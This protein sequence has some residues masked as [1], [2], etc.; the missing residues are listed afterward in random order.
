V[1]KKFSVKHQCRDSRHNDSEKKFC[2]CYQHLL[3]SLCEIRCWGQQ[4][5]QLS[6]CEWRD[7]RQNEGRSLAV[8]VSV[9]YRERY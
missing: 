7:S 6:T 8:G 9:A 5:M 2:Q 1:Y 3:F 4:I